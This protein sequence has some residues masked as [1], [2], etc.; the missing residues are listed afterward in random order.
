MKK[1]RVLSAVVA[2]AL[3]VVNTFALNTT[4]NGRFESTDAYTASV[5]LR[6]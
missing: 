2:F 1:S 4:G 5:E 3:A 6:F